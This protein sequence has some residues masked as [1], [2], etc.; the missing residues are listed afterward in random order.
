MRM[1]KTEDLK[2]QIEILSQKYQRDLDTKEAFIQLLDKNL[3][4][5]EDQFQMALKNHLMH[6]ESLMSVQEARIRGLQDEFRRNV[7]ILQY[8][9]EKERTDMEKTHNSQIKELE[10]TIQTVKEEQRRIMEEA[11]QQEQAYREEVKNWNL[12]EESSMKT[13]LDTK[14]GNHF[15]ELEQM[16]QKFTADL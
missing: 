13:T 11:K 6:V 12:E 16:S 4:E 1:A 10:D 5:A 2:N 15:T 3:D 14:Q 8:E 9:Y 7:E